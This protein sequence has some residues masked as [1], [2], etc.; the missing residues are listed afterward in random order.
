MRGAR[1]PQ[2]GHRALVMASLT[3][4]ALIRNRDATWCIVRGRESA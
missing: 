4:R 3:R 2:L 1:D